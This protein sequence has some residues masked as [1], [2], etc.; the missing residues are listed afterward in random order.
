MFPTILSQRVATALLFLI[1]L[2]SYHADAQNFLVFTDS[3]KKHRFNDPEKALVFA[4]NA[5]RSAE[6]KQEIAKAKLLLGTLYYD[7]SRYD[8]ALILLRDANKDF[9]ASGDSAGI[10]D[11]FKGIGNVYEYQG[12]NDSAL[13]YYTRAYDI[14]KRSGN[15]AEIAAGLN[16]MGNIYVYLNAYPKALSLFLEALDL[17]K[18][19]KDFK[20]ETNL[21]NNIG[22]VYDYNNDLDKALEYYKKAQSGYEILKDDAGLAGALNNLGLVYK[23]KGL[24]EQAIP[25]YDKALLLFSKLKSPWGVA[26]LENNLG[27]AYGLMNDQASAIRYHQRALATNAAIGNLDGVAN[28]NNSLGDCYLALK[29]YN[30]AKA[31]Y[32]KGLEFSERIKAR[33]RKAESL[34][35]LAKT[36]EGSN[37][38]K[39]ALKFFKAAKVLRDSILNLEKSQKLYEL[40]QKYESQLKQK[41]IE[42]LNAESE[43][44]KLEISEQQALLSKRNLQLL[45]VGSSMVLIAIVV[46]LL[47]SRMRLLQQKKLEAI[48]VE[49]EQAV[50]RSLYEQRLNISKDMHDEI[51]SGLTHIAMVSELM[52][53]QRKSGEELHRDVQT[54]SETSRKLIENMSDIVWAINPKNESLEN[55]IAYIREQTTRYF[56]PFDVN[57]IIDIDSNIPDRRLTNLQRRNLFLVTKES[58]NNAL[59]HASPKEVKLSIH[60]DE[61]LLKFYIEDN[62]RGF[63]SEKIRK[64]ANGLKNMRSRMEQI[65]GSFEIENLHPGTRVSYTMPLPAEATI[66]LL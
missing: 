15:V 25:Y 18:S 29:D 37:D 28:S 32:Q 63:D 44:Q 66:L 34:E 7:V 42:L 17:S 14:S 10:A 39:S 46:Y 45:F 24:P 5:Q 53:M 41:Q 33:D 12:A 22:M 64:T 16:S 51:G 47:Y 1:Y 52:S 31:S 35:G 60:V 23:N 58:L 3:A 26:V 65:G 59:K 6:S 11:A 9:S 49:K 8:S 55:L 40:E 48:R 21:Y 19:L 38:F 57:Y 56:E 2:Y 4:L 36:S 13:F 27:V 54:I 20:L 62:G 61:N 30:R 50:F 43:R